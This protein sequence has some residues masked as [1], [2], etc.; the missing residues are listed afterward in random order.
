MGKTIQEAGRHTGE[1]YDLLKARERV[2]RG[3]TVSVTDTFEDPSVDEPFPWRILVR[4]EPEPEQAF[5]MLEMSPGGA[6]VELGPNRAAREQGVEGIQ[7]RLPVRLDHQ[8]IFDNR[9]FGTLEEM[10]SAIAD[11]LH[12]ML[13]LIRLR[14]R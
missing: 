8:L 12:D 3:F 6:E 13:E 9:G 10:A 4:L 2:S 11:Y 1:L 7:D 5:A 14:D